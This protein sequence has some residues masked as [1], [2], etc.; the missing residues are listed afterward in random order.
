MLRFFW[1]YLLTIW[2]FPS[3][4]IINYPKLGGLYGQTHW[5]LTR[6]NHGALPSF[7]QELLNFLCLPDVLTKRGLSWNIWG[8]LEWGTPKTR[9]HKTKKSSSFGWFEGTTFFWKP[10]YLSMAEIELGHPLNGCPRVRSHAGCSEDMMLS[11]S[12]C[13]VEQIHRWTGLFH[14]LVG[15]F[16]QNPT[17]SYRYQTVT[18]E[19]KRPYV[20]F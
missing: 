18:S 15:C 12:S 11:K 6:D 7:Q 8:F 1:D 5:K 9:L 3:R 13:I 14:I 17:N 2:K 10:P 19:L 16:Q 20:G 4:G